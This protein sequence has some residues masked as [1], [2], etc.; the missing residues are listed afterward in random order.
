MT[1]QTHAYHIA[2]SEVFITRLALTLELS[3]YFTLL[4]ASEYYETA[5]TISDGVHRSTVFITKGFHGLHVIVCSIFPNCL[6]P[7]PTTTDTE[8]SSPYK[9]G[10]DPIGF[11]IK[12]FLVAVTF[13]PLIE[14]NCPASAPALSNYTYD[15]KNACRSPYRLIYDSCSPTT[16]TWWLRITIILKPIADPWPTNIS[17]T[18]GSMMTTSKSYRPSPAPNNQLN[19]RTI[20]SNIIFLLVQYHHYPRRG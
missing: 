2:S 8:K 3:V 19:Q 5:F 20:C 14:R 9:C 10:F 12:I 18:N 4:Q 7:V 16:Q 13:L 11:S 15:V 17:S 1:H 6:L